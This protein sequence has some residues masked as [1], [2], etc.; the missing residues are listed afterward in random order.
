MISRYLEFAADALEQ[1]V[2]EN[3]Q[4]QLKIDTPEIVMPD[5]EELEA[6]PEQTA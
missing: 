4:W 3:G 5:E 2:G 1:F 6:I